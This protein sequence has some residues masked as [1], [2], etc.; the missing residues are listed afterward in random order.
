MFTIWRGFSQ[1]VS[2]NVLIWN[3]SGI[4]QNNLFKNWIIEPN[5]VDVYMFT[6]K[7]YQNE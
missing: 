1:T 4:L 2:L 5:K 7:G 6:N 3:I